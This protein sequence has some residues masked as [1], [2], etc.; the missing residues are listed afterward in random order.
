MSA[1]R[2]TELPLVGTVH[3]DGVAYR[4]EIP[5]SVDT[6]SALICE[7]WCSKLQV[8]DFGGPHFRAMCVVDGEP[9]VLTGRIA[10][11]DA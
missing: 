5:V 6:V 9:F 8:S 10:G 11:G 2:I 3:P 7:S 4:V 1:R